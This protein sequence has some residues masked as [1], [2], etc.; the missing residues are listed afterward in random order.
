MENMN[1]KLLE[2]IIRLIILFKSGGYTF[3]ILVNRLDQTIENLKNP[4]KEWIE[5][6]RE[7]WFSLEMINAVIL[8]E[9]SSDN[10]SEHQNEIDRILDIF[11]DHLR[12]FKE[13]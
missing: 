5:K 13:A 1:N 8:D 11:D 2:D 6:A 12:S 3:P 7:L 4:D 10:Q 9:S